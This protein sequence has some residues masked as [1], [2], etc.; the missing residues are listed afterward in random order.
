[1]EMDG[2]VDKTRK[3][4]S[5]PAE[6]FASRFFNVVGIAWVV[7]LLF[8]IGVQHSRNINAA[9]HQPE[10]VSEPE[11]L[12]TISYLPAQFPRNWASA[13]VAEHVQAF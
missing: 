10:R 12:A 9:E 4:Q 5:D 1:M 7:A 13:T 6:K 3:H 11:S 8:V 2:V